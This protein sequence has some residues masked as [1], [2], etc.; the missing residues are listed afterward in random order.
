LALPPA[1][2]Q[3]QWGAQ[4][5]QAPLPPAYGPPPQ[6]EAP[7]EFG[8]FEPFHARQ[9]PR[10]EDGPQGG[11]FRG[12]PRQPPR[13]HDRGRPGA[14]LAL[15]VILLVILLGGGTAAG[16]LLTHRSGATAASQQATAAGTPSGSGRASAGTAASAGASPT[17]SASAAAVTERQAAGNVATLLGKSVADRASINHAYSDVMSCGAGLPADAK[18]F[19]DAATSRRGLLS[20]L[21]TVGGRA[22]LPP[23]LL[24]DLTQAW[25]SSVAA[26][27]ALAR[28]TNDEIAKGCVRGDTA[29]PG[30][31]ATVTPDSNATRDK[32]AFAAGWNPLAAKYG[33]R[34]YHQDQ[35]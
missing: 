10:R 4:G 24:G 16:L 25:Q 26:D 28:W 34:Q 22:T 6:G 7:T 9:P 15:W 3:G 33:L 14:P 32:T 21:A 2:P 35:L 11:P 13:R 27:Q 20:K 12:P 5:P 31:Q 8:G 19:S 29:D 23:A 18:V 1:Q 17:A 30:Y